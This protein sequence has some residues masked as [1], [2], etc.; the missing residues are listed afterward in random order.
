MFLLNVLVFF[1]LVHSI[2][3]IF[4]GGFVTCTGY[5]MIKSVFSISI[6]LCFYH[7]CVL[8]IFKVI[9]S[10]YFEI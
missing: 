3:Y 7:F 1:S 8:G 5:V 10:R 4:M 2:L 6:T 9:S